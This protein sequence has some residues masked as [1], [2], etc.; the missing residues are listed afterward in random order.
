MSWSEPVNN[1]APILNY[2]VCITEQSS[3]GS[4]THVV[5]GNTTVI[6]V[7][8]LQPFTVYTVMVAA[9][10]RVGMSADSEPLLVRTNESSKYAIYN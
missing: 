7:S 5:D 8:G 1:N 2:T 3:G 10:N 6:P 4:T 9:Q